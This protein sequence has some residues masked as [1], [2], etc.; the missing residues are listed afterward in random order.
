MS[1]VAIVGR[2]N[3]GK[4]TLFN[5]LVGKR[6][7][8]VEDTPGVTRDR[9]YAEVE[10]TGR[11]FTLVDTG[12]I[13]TVSEDILLK[14]MR[15]QAEAAIDEA[16]LVVFLVDGRQGVTASDEEVARILRNTQKPVIL[17]VNKL[18]VPALFPHTADF[19]RLGL[20]EP[21]AISAANGMN[22]GDLLDIIVNRLPNCEEPVYGEDIIKITVMGRPNVGKSSLV[23]TVL[24]ENRVIVSDIPGTTRDAVDT[25][26]ERDQNK[27][28][29]IDTAG[30]RKKA[31]I[32]E[33]I[34]RY[35]VVRSLRA[36][37]KADICLMVIDATEGVLEQDKKIVG[38]AHEKGKGLIFVINKWDLVE[39]DDKT[40]D[41]FKKTLM[42]EFLFA[43]YAPCI[44]VSAKT[45]QRVQKIL[46][47]VQHVH[48]EQTK[49]VATS[50]LMELVTEATLVTP[51]PQER[52]R[53]LKIGYVTQIEIK[54]P[55]FVFFVNEPEL[56]HF[57]Y[58]R[59]LE[60][61]IRA[62]YTFEGTP[63]RMVTR[64]KE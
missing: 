8:I 26:F 64:K 6:I 2:P 48:K 56:M 57:S 63:V 13:D 5:Y 4:S 58:Q 30:L 60:N 55:T 34:E 20:D 50:A 53:K 31:K 22:L 38:Y 23:N 45:G 51:P 3:V 44:F 9:I 29:I 14:Q 19:F 32:K 41:K 33:D 25:Y 61:R 10:W 16:D 36:V 62:V 1:Y 18:D 21:V 15:Y 54:P 46:E 11:R 49:K 17:A 43:D 28:V 35:S 7:S 59:F 39:K 12:G 42:A 52:G 47:I 37:D 40:A 27:Y 24:G